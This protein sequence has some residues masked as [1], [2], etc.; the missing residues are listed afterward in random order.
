MPKPPAPILQHSGT[1]RDLANADVQRL[2]DLP[3]RHSPL[4]RLNQLPPLRDGF[5]F[6]GGKD[7]LQKHFGF[8]GILN[9]GKELIEFPEVLF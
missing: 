9:R 5:Q 6:L 3:L 2:R 1:P 8:F 4:Q 7:V